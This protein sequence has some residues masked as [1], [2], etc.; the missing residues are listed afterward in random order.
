MP[1]TV[2]SKTIYYPET[3]TLKVIFVSG[4]IYDYKDVPEEIYNAMKTSGAKGIYLNRYI[5]GKYQF[6]KINDN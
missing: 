2:I 5:K 4:M 3:A 6:K 1:S